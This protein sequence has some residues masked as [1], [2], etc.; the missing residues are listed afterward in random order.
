MRD[1]TFQGEIQFQ[2]AADLRQKVA[3][4]LLDRADLI[5]NDSVAVFPFSGP[6]PLE[7]AFCTRLGELLVQL[8]AMA[9]RDGKPDSRGALVADLHRTVQ[10]RAL[11]VEQLFYFVYLTERTALDELAVSDTIGA[12]TESWPLTAQLT[13]RASFDLLAAYTMR[14]QSEPTESAI[15]DRLT[16]LHTRPVIEAVL[17]REVDRAARFGYPVSL[18]LFDVDHLSKI[19]DEHG[20]GV[21]DRILERMGILIRKYFRQLDWVGRHCEDSMLVLLPQ[22]GGEDASCLAER[23]RRMVEERLG[24]RDH[25]NERRVRVTVS[26][27]VVNVQGIGGDLIDAERLLI[28]AEIALTRAKETGRNRVE[29]VDLLPASMSLTDA[30]RSLGASRTA[31]RK[32]IAAGTLPA[33]RA[34][35]H[36]RVDRASLDAYRE[37]RIA[38]GGLRNGKSKS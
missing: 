13:R 32:L 19:N 8:L 15:I 18:I 2:S 29:R 24:F 4:L 33:I 20:Y 11:S 6:Q 7:A 26:A 5:I 22:T 34:G 30:A 16:T 28:E 27:A 23:T 31:V 1:E 25:R 3:E 14:A 10:E 17:A 35:R 21:G 38:D 36:V 37:M 9:V 12:T